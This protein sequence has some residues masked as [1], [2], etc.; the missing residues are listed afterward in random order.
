MRGNRR[1]AAHSRT[2]NIPPANGRRRRCQAS[3][4]NQ[5]LTFHTRPTAFPRKPPTL[6]T[7]SKPIVATRGSLHA[8][9]C[10]PRYSPVGQTK[11]N[12]LVR[13]CNEHTDNQIIVRVTN[14]PGFP[15]RLRLLQGRSPQG[16]SPPSPQLLHPC[17]TPSPRSRHLRRRN[18]PHQSCR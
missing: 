17:S 3:Y 7:T 10:R 16:N 5:G 6:G 9:L 8:N 14:L 18:S 13:R 1:I 15:C 11:A 4:Q 12:D 2:G